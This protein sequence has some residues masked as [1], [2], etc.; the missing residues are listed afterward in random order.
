[1]D[2]ESPVRLHHDQPGRF[3]Q[4][5]V[6]TARVVDRAACDHQSHEALVGEGNSLP[7]L[8]PSF[9]LQPKT[10]HPSVLGGGKST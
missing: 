3:G 4:M 1:M 9:Q 7:T 5:G 10:S 2:G 6:E 8:C